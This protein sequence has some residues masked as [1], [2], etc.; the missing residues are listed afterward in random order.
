[1]R[2]TGEKIVAESRI[3]GLDV[4]SESAVDL[5]GSAGV[6]R[7]G[8]LGVRRSRNSGHGLFHLVHKTT[9]DDYR[10]LVER[11]LYHSNE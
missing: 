10:V 2:E 11:L 1:M 4:I 9:W 7:G 8:S 3:L 5:G 6:Q